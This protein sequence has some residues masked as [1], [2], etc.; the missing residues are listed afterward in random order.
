MAVKHICT[1][2]DHH[3]NALLGI[4][5][6]YRGNDPDK[7]LDCW[8]L[9]CYFQEELRGIRMHSHK[10]VYREKHL[11]DAAVRHE[12]HWYRLGVGDK[13]RYGDILLFSPVGGVVHCGVALDYQTMLHTS[14]GYMSRPE[15]FN[16][17]IWRP[18]LATA[19][20]GVYRYNAG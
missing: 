2:W 13:I 11:L 5:F 18:R 15:V 1:E 7:G 6:K 12:V 20:F 8:G 4:P 9:V 3:V 14:V 17:A 16:N 10:E 19:P